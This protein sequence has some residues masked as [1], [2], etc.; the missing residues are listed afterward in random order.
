MCLWPKLIIRQNS[1]AYCGSERFKHDL[2]KKNCLLIIWVD[3]K[4]PKY[5]H[6]TEVDTWKRDMEMM[7]RKMG[8]QA[9]EC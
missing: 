1:A 5:P 3:F 6:M 9:K 2:E 8:L 7:W 4:C